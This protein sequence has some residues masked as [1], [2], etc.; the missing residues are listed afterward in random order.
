M[1]LAVAA[2]AYLALPLLLKPSL[3][4]A[5]REQGFTKASI[6]QIKFLSNGIY[7][8]KI[9]L[10]PNGFTQAEDIQ[11]TGSWRDMALNHTAES[12]SIKNISVSAELND[13]YRLN[14]AGWENPE[15]P[16]SDNSDLP[17]R[18]LLVDGIT[19]DADTPVGVIRVVG[20][21]SLQD[22]ADKNK[23]IAASFV[24]SQQQLSGN[25]E[26][27]ARMSPAN[28]TITGQITLNE[29]ALDIAPVLAARVTGDIA[30]V[31]GDTTQ[32]SGKMAAGLLKYQ[33][34]PL[35]NS[36]LV[37]D[38]SKDPVASFKSRLVGRPVAIAADFKRVPKDVLNFA[39]KTDTLNDLYKIAQP[40]A[41]D[42]PWL[43]KTGPAEING[44]I[45]PNFLKTKELVL[46]L[47]SAFSGGNISVAPFI[48]NTDK[49]AGNPVMELKKVSI[50]QLVEKDA[51]MAV[52][53]KMS[54][55]L[56]LRVKGSDIFIDNGVLQSDGSG[57]IRYQPEKM[58]AALQG[59]DPRMETVRLALS[60]Y[61]YDS[62]SIGLNGAVNGNL[63]TTFAAKGKSPAFPNRPVN[64]NLNLEGA[65][66]SALQQALQ[67]G[68]LTDTIKQE[69]TKGNR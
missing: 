11:V 60:N 42:N 12:I 66:T 34:I 16:S 38:T 27:K 4:M 46:S 43:L 40:D 24:T 2:V 55:R 25:I 45:E 23:N 30:F 31:I 22:A 54:G 7:I 1:I 18:S 8:D 62:L 47:R 35:E 28:K 26:L 6:G 63:K 20:K 36:N 59:D 69:I 61:Q 14:I 53:G 15:K 39:I 44:A 13:Q 17:F 49:K 56:P 3:E 50:D 57:T 41:E 52:Q 58:P 68:I 9:L 33:Q 32:F 19:L 65:L 51:S 5:I 67:P 48:F 10:E 64:L 29:G 21:L 37:F